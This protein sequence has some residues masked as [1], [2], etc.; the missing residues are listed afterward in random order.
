[1]NPRDSDDLNLAMD[2]DAQS[3]SS[4]RGSILSISDLDNPLDFK[5]KENSSLFLTLFGLMN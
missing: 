4:N 5:K 3:P 2:P 1:M